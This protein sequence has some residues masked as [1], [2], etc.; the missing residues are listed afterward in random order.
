[1]LILA[2]LLHHSHPHPSVAPYT[3]PA[4]SRFGDALLICPGAP[5]LTNT[6]SFL[7]D[8]N[9]DMVTPELIHQLWAVI[10][11]TS[12][13]GVEMPN[14]WIGNSSAPEEWWKGLPVGEVKII[15]GGDET[16]RDDIA[17]WSGYL[18]VSKPGR[19]C[20]RKSLT[21]RS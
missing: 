4:G 9:P 20:A 11:S 5:V 15:V 19:L 3:L 8:P 18:K 12:E 6:A 13:E 2:F 14:P 1:M 10:T 17:I 7:Q 16:L 21:L